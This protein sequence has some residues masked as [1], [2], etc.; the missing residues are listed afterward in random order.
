MG[1]EVKM[2]FYGGG[3][4]AYISIDFNVCSRSNY[5]GL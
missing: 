5:C 3:S 4:Y 1:Y 2:S